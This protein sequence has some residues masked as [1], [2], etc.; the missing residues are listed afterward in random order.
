MMRTGE[1]GPRDIEGQRRWLAR[2]S[3]LGDLDARRA[4]A[5]SYLDEEPARATIGLV[6]QSSWPKRDPSRRRTGS[7]SASRTR[8]ACRATIPA[9]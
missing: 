9:P 7:A 4:L 3:G 1:G 8:M 5:N 6:L 2:A